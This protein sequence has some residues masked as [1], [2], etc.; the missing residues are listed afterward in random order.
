VVGGLVVVAAIIVILVLALGG[1]DDNK[2]QPVASGTPSAPPSTASA[3]PSASPTPSE[4]P[5][6]ET[7]TSPNAGGPA[8]GRYV[9]STSSGRQIGNFTLTDVTYRTGGGGSGIWSWD[10]DTDDITFTGT[11]LSDFNGSYDSTTGDIDLVAKDKTVS[12][13]CSQ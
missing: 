11:D 5:S 2:S 10:E 7:S 3:S 4:S 1:G 8:T 6:D 9:C 12:L 13:T